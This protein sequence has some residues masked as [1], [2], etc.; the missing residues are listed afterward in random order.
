MPQDSRLYIDDIWKPSSTSTRTHRLHRLQF[1]RSQPY[2][3]HR[4]PPNSQSSRQP[5][6][7]NAQQTTADNNAAYVVATHSV[8]PTLHHTHEY[9]AP[10]VRNP[11]T[12]AQTDTQHPHV[13]NLVMPSSYPLHIHRFFL[14]VLIRITNL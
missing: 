9:G 11:E 5:H 10:Q 2:I 3:N 8:S 12:P 6:S 14:R 4:H 7:Y 13:R 1:R